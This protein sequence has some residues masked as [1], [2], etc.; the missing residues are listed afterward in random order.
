MMQTESETDPVG[1]GWE[2]FS[3]ATGCKQGNSVCSDVVLDGGASG[4]LCPLAF[5]PVWASR[6]VL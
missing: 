2:F 6:Q 1:S 3:V 4:A 5:P